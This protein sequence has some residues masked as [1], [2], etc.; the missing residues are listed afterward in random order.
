MSLD[1][2]PNP[3]IFKLQYLDDGGKGWKSSE[4]LSVKE[5]FYSKIQIDIS[6][7]IFTFVYQ[8]SLKKGHIFSGTL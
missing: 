1:N 4:N 5:A 3:F 2:R 6:K 8:R 7:Y